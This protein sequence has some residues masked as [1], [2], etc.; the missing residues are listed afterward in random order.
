[1]TVGKEIQV[2][3]TAQGVWVAIPLFIEFT[4]KLNWSS[5]AKFSGLSVLTLG[6]A[7]NFHIVSCNKY[8]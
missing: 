6:I 7:D 1:M 8:D 4:P 3:L 2:Y 5:F